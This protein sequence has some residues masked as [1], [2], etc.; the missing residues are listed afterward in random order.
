MQLRVVA[1]HGK[2]RVFQGIPMPLTSCARGAEDC[3][4]D[5]TELCATRAGPCEVGSI[6]VPLG[7]R[8]RVRHRGGVFVL[9]CGEAGLDPFV[10]P[11]ENGAEGR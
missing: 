9:A 6:T 5:L 11:T 2:V 4:F 10:Y 7:D 8:R 3:S 1:R